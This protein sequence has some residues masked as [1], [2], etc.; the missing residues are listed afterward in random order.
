[1]N[2]HPDEQFRSFP[3]RAGKIFRAIQAE[4][5]GKV[6]VI[7][8]RQELRAPSQRGRRETERPECVPHVV[9]AVAKGPFTVF[10][11]LAPDDGS[12]PDVES[13]RVG[14]G[15]LRPARPLFQGVMQRRVV[16]DTGATRQ[17]FE[18]GQD[19][20]GFRRMQV[21]AGRVHPQIPTRSSNLLSCGKTQ[22][23]FK[24]QTQR[25][26][27]ERSRRHG[28]RAEQGGRRGRVVRA[29]QRESD[30]RRGGEAAEGVRLIRPVQAARAVGVT[31]GMMLGPVVI[32]DD[33]ADCIVLCRV[34]G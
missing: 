10:P 34:V 31:L 3:F 2:D 27:R 12:Q 13:G 6:R 9:L 16:I 5:P 15:V 33:A 22:G 21:A 19:G 29:G 26:E 18:G 8:L 20:V 17:P 7:P 25:A 1:M 4:Q 23:Q 28:R 30:H 14:F 32:G 11:R 24:E